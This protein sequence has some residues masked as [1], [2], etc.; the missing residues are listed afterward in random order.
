MAWR[1][2]RKRR[3]EDFRAELEAH[4]DLESELLRER[5]MGEAGARRAARRTVGNLTRIQERFY[6]SGLKLALRGLRAA[7][8]F[9]LA[10][11]ATLAV[12]IGANAVVFAA[13][14]AVVRHPLPVPQARSLFVLQPHPDNT[15]LEESYPDY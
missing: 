14:N 11:V 6:E 10:A 3:A 9:T 12:A 4:V 8:S 1:L 15:S 5:G 2:R 7:P 13:L